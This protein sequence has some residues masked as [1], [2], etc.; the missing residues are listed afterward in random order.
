MNLD[1]ITRPNI[2]KLKAY[3]SA[4][5]EFSGKAKIYLDANENPFSN[6]L[7]RYPDP[8][9]KAVKKLFSKLR[10]VPVNNILLG[11]GSDEILDLIIRAFCEPGQD[12][13]LTISPTYGMYKILADIQNVGIST[14]RLDESF[15]LDIKQLL[16]CISEKTKLIFLCS[17]NNP[18]G[19]C[20]KREDIYKIATDFEGL[21]VVDEA[22]V[23]FCP[24][25]SILKD[26]QAPENIVVCQ[27]LSKAYG[28]AG[29][30]LGICY[31]QAEIIS[32]LQRIKAPYNI[33]QLTI[34]KALEV[35]NGDQTIQAQLNLILQ[36]REKLV[37]ALTPLALVSKVYPSS[38][39]F[40]LVRMTNSTLV[41]QA[42]LEQGIVT[43]NRNTEAGCSNCLRISIGTPEENQKL[44]NVLSA[45]KIES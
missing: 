26:P 30:R 43:R 6:G 27:T 28:L 18:T 40:L 38:A 22:Y 37:K 21:V 19:Q 9:Q 35:L 29:I 8:E 1:N 45:L 31:A 7:N 25:N 20:V 44:I 23:D 42:L 11:N 10:N 34:N 14:C 5:D 33:N 36:E 16:N 39:N 12:E 32:I 13:I 15:N 4:R 3:S 24:E 41:Y 2:Q 17:P